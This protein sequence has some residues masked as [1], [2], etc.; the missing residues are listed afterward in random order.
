MTDRTKASV[1]FLIKRR[2]NKES[3][4]NVQNVV[5]PEVNAPAVSNVDHKQEKIAQTSLTTESV[6]LADETQS[7]KDN[8]KSQE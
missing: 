5:V 2:N 1:R 4:F 3:E 7:V 6:T 8:H